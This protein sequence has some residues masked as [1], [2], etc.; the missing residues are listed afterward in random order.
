MWYDMYHVKVSVDDAALR[1]VCHTRIIL[2]DVWQAIQKIVRYELV[3]RLESFQEEGILIFARRRRCSQI[4]TDVEIC[5]FAEEH[6][7]FDEE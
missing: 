7:S 4:T 1:S 5:Y 2:I 3:K 6:D